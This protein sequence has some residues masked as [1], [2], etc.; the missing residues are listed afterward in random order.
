MSRTGPSPVKSV[1]VTSDGVTHHGAYFVQRSTV[2]VR[3]P[4]G[5]KAIQVGGAEPVAIARLLLLELVRATQA[6][7]R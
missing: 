3:S 2:Y 1:T 5:D 4:L 6:S 7:P